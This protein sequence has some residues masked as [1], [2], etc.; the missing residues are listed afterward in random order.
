[1]TND[2]PLI[3]AYH[4]IVTGRQSRY[5]MSVGAFERQLTRLLDDG[6]VPLTLEQAIE[7]GPF[8][9]AD[10]KPKSFTITFD[11]GLVSLKTLAL[12]VL[13][14]LGLAQQTATFVPTAHVGADNAWRTK[15]TLLQRIMPWS[16][17]EEGLLGWDEIGELAQAGV[18][19]ESHGHGHLAMNELSY[20]D[21]LADVRESLRL[22]GEHG[23]APRY[24]ALPFGWHSPESERAIADAG[25][26]AALSVKWG[27]LNRY[28]IRRI[29]IYGTDSALTTRLKFSGRYF[30]A[31][32]TAA[33]LAGKKRYRR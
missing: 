15:P 23:H 7:S 18:A 33:R 10:A 26:D 22:L 24:F 11:D 5:A 27:G 4:H 31:F 13:R 32:D 9:S 2:W 21:A 12:P 29:P 3:L 14:R 8:G 16:E 19:V 1:M 28:E 25:L 30:D 20:D 6:F 17:V